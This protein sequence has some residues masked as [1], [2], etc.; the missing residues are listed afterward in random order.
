M[1]TKRIYA[2]PEKNDGFRILVDRLWPRGLSKNKAKVD[3]WLKDA[4]PSNELRKWF[5]HDPKK[6]GEFKRRYFKELN[7]KKKLI[8]LICNNAGKG[9]VALVYGAKNERFN[10]AIALKEYIESQIDNLKKD[11]INKKTDRRA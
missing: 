3:L 6:W 7:S 10:N 8:E 9:I 5:S 2:K 11:E 4:A 1:K